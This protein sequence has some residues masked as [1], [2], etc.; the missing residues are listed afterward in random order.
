MRRA[1]AGAA[2]FG[3]DQLSAQRSMPSFS[4]TQW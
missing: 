3:A 1:R 2:P 4:V